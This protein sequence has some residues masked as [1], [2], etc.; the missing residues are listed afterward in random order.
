MPSSPYDLMLI[1]TLVWFVLA[2]ALFQALA[3]V[4]RLERLM[5]VRSRR[6][7]RPLPKQSNIRQVPVRVEKRAG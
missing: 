6:R 1:L 4:R 2:V 7:R 5:G 3:R